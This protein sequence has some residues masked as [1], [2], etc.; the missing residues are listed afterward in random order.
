MG[1]AKLLGLLICMMLAAVLAVSCAAGASA[2]TPGASLAASPS[3][4]LVQSPGTASSPALS[5]TSTSL[6]SDDWPTYHGDLSRN[7]FRPGTSPGASTHILWR[8]DTLD[9]DVYAEPLIV[10]GSVLAATES[11]SVYSL[12]IKT[13]KVQWKVNLGTPVPLSELSCGDIDP[14]G[15]TSTPAADPAAGR[16]YVVARIQPNH[17]ELFVLDLTNGSTI[18]HQTV[19]PAGSGPK[20]QQQRSALALAN[21]KVYIAF[22]G[23]AGDCGNYHGYLVEASKTGA[24]QPI[25]YQVSKNIG[26]AL[27][28]PSGP[29]ADNAGNIYVTSGN[30]D[31][32]STFDNGNAVLRLSAGLTLQDW[33]APSNWQDLDNGDVDLGSMGPLLLQGGLIFQAGKEGK[34]YLLKASNLGH[35]GGELFSAS[36]GQGAYGGAAYAPPYVFVPCSDGL[37]ALTIDTSTPAFDAAWA[38]PGISPGPPVVAGSTVITINTGNGTLYGFSTDKGDSLFQISLGAVAHFATPALSGSQI[39]AAADR[40]IVCLGP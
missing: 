38:S 26:G 31:S 35:I 13:G 5:A 17:H 15:I 11:N 2:T 22:G 40:Q 23:L 12:N 34:G 36:I 27:W 18:A 14:S 30:T 8:S 20:V 29:A 28:A 21:D 10:E 37:K 7:G 6:S 3:T 25:T 1:P 32:G 19:D 39:F 9:G 24:G 4:S 33:F 16:L